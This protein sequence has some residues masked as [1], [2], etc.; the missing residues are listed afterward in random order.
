MTTGSLVNGTVQGMANGLGGGGVSGLDIGEITNVT[1]NPNGVLQAMIAGQIAWDGIAEQAY[2]TGA[3]G[4]T[5]FKVG[6]VA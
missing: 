6:S 4:S 5:W 2:Q 1:G 3:I